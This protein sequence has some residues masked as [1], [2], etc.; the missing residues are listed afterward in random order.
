MRLDSYTDVIA[1]PQELRNTAT[2]NRAN[3]FRSFRV[4]FGV[5]KL[6]L[7]RSIHGI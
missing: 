5:L 1:Q 6:D 7:G 4:S 3:P 2:A